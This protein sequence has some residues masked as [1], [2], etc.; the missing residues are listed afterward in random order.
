MR[1]LATIAFSF[2][3][4]IFAA[5]LLPWEGWYPA[6]V[7]ICALIGLGICLLRRWKYRRRGLLIAFSLCAG[8]LY[9]IAFQTFFL[10]P[11]EKL[12][13]TESSFR[14]IVIDDP[15]TAE[16]GAK[17]EVRL[18]DCRGVRAVYYGNEEIFTL[19]PGN[20][21]SGTAK[22]NVVEYRNVLAKGNYVLLYDRDDLTIES[23]HTQSIRWWPQRMG[24]AFREEIAELWHNENVSSFLTAE[25]TGDKSDVI[26]ED[27]SALQETG[28]AHLFAVSGL[29]CA[30]LTSMIGLFIP[31]TRRRLSCI[32]TIGILLFY[33]C[34]TGLTPSVV[35]ACIM[36]IFLVT[37]PLFFRGS[38]GLTSL[39]AALFVILVGN[40]YAAGSVSL[41]LSFS[42]TAGL[43][44]L[45]PGIYREMMNRFTGAKKTVKRAASFAAANLSASFGTMVFTVPLVAYYFNIFSLVSPL[46]GLLTIWA[47][48]WSFMA[49]F[50]AT[51]LGMIWNPL[52]RIVGLFAAAAVQYILWVARTL[53]RIPYHAVYFTGDNLRYWLGY[54]YVLFGACF[55]ARKEKSRKYIAAA[56]L[57]VLMLVAALCCNSSIYRA[58]KM[59]VTVMDVGQGQSVL[60]CSENR[61]ALVDC[62]TSSEEKNAGDIVAE[63]LASRGLLSLDALVVTHYHAD[64]TNGLKMLLSRISVDTMYLPDIEDEY[65]VREELVQLAERY[66]SAVVWVCQETEM[67][68][69]NGKLKIYPPVGTEDLNEQCISVLATEEDFDVLITGDMSGETECSLAERFSLPDTEVLVVSHHGSKHSSYREFLEEIN[70]D[71]AVISVGENS[72]GHPAQET[73]WRLDNAGAEI[74]RTDIAGHVTIQGQGE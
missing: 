66:G 10:K 44:L 2:S 29:H 13:D 35:R 57:S 8:L 71:V 55:V 22:W 65:G 32:L 23:G 64:H 18:R 17:V 70:P 53:T 19:E 74:Y 51:L 26:E 54:T 52:G 21:I 62:G 5:V 73:L 49:G 39:S 9:F 40:P 1:V 48:G 50:A 46:A 42:A 28:L 41:Q 72:Y 59:S 15:Q 34:M 27:Y 11:L 61:A 58:G 56:V 31:K 38:D 4:A 6:A 43:V 47:A 37:A 68:L 30:F 45:T 33:M 25:L 69:G 67:P 20:V 3:A 16:F 14:A 24:K 63:E 36:Q 60:L 7:A 12:D